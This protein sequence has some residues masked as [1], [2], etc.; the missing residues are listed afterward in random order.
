MT[1]REMAEITSMSSDKLRAQVAS[2]FE[3]FMMYMLI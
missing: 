2:K 1:W 3:F